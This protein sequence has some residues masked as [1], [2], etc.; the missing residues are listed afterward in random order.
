M[1]AAQARGVPVY[2]CTADSAPRRANSAVLLGAWL[3]LFHKC[4]AESAWNAVRGAGPFA[5]FRDASCGPSQFDLT[6]Q[7][8][9]Q[10]CRCAA[11]RACATRAQGS[12]DCVTASSHSLRA[13]AKH[14]KLLLRLQRIQAAFTSL[15]GRP[16]QLITRT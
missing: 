12:L 5:P 15:C 4:D 13:V 9:L 6:V 14:G 3:V 2:F 10:V 16:L 7:H 8:V 1:Q 11:L